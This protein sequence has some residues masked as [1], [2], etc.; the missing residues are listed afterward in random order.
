MDKVY[1]PS[2]VEKNWYNQWENNGFF[3]PDPSKENSFSI[4]IPPPNVTGSLHIGHALNNTLQ[5]ILIRYHRMAGYSSLWIPG[6]DHAGIATQNVVERALAKEGTSRHDLGREKFIQKVWEWRESYGKRILKQLR[7]MGFSL[8]WT[9]ERFTMDKGLSNAVK[10]V[11]VKLYEEGYIYKGKYIVNWCPR[12]LTAL[13]DIEVEHQINQGHIWHI[14]Y[15]EN[16]TVA[17]TRP[18]TIF[19]DTAIAVHPKDLRYQDLIGTK[20]TLPLVNKEIPIITDEFV[21][22]NFGTGAVKITPAHDPNDFAAAKRHNLPIVMI[23]NESAIMNEQVPEKY[24]NLDRYECRKKVVEDLDKLNLLVKIEDHENSVG[25]CYRCKTTI[26]PYLS[27]QWFVKMKD[28]VKKPL[29]AVRSKE[30]EIIPNRWEKLFFDWMENIRD[31]CISRQIWWG[32]R[33]PVWYCDKCTNSKSNLEKENNHCNQGIIVSRETPKKCPICN[34]TN[35]RQ[36]PDV[37]DTWFSSA[38]WPF[39]TLGWPEK[40]K[41][42]EKYYPT[43]VLVTGYDILTFWVSRMLTMGYKFIGKKPFSKVYVHGLVRDETGKKMSK[44]TGNVI[45]PLATVEKYSADA[46]RFT[47]A[48]LLTTGG[49]DIKLSEEKIQASR[50]FLNKIWNVTRYTIQKKQTQNIKGD[51]KHIADKWILSRCHHTVNKVTSYLNKFQF[52]EATNLLYEFVWGEFCDWYIEM[53]KVA[54]STNVLVF[55]LKTILKLLHPIVPFVTEELWHKLGEDNFIIKSE[56]P[57]C[58]DNMINRP[59]EEEIVLIIEI[60]KSIRNI[61][62]EMNIP[63]QK[64]ANII[65][66]SV[67]S[68]IIENIKKNTSYIKFLAKVKDINFIDDLLQKPPKASTVIINNVQIFMPLAD[69]IDSEKEIVRLKK[70]LNKVRQDLDFAQRKLNN[71]SFIDKAPKEVVQKQKEKEELL[72]EKQRIILGQIEQIT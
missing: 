5:D 58:N 38:L 65:I 52:G 15:S 45:D 31:W 64:E 51:H 3:S 69:L 42:I 35:L 60:I 33:I 62:A 29:A 70:E 53:N 8:D 67:K 71:Q 30:V 66:Y 26:E 59:L 1:D 41:E 25:H 49:Q 43:S 4:V 21:D 18:E 40:T 14:K 12:C 10:E 46:L 6:T 39:S 7:Y 54:G 50:N 2:K 68:T 44:S 9:R 11:F 23:M 56:W 55:V 17:T 27:T 48:S 20:I 16:I 63:A 61:R 72:L 34:N 57:N 13:S 47:L 28:L 32:H 36:D 37:L 24:R 22:K 19:G